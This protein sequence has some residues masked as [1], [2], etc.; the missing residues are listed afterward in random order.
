MDTSTLYSATAVYLSC[1]VAA[2]SAS[3]STCAITQF[4]VYSSN[5]VTFSVVNSCYTP[6]THTDYSYA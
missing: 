5:T 6:L 2:A 3:G 4:Y 1:S